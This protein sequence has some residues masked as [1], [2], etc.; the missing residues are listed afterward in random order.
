MDQSQAR[1]RGPIAVGLLLIALGGVFLVGQM[2][3]ID[4]GRYGWPL[5]II[6]PGVAIWLVALML[7]GPVGVGFS[8]AGAITTVTGFVL[9]YQDTTDHWES[10]A[11]AW[12]LI[13]PGAV[14]L[15]LAVHGLVHGDRELLDSGVRVALVGLAL[16]LV[17]G[18]FFESMVGLG[19][20]PSSTLRDTILPGGL[21]VLGIGIVLAG[22]LSGRRHRT[23]A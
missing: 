13:A 18:V 16:F 7:G 10:W 21:V 5:F 8:I 22:I 17:F 19:D 1:E 11:Y 4:F 15:A 14:G 23:P 3:D 9:L 12:A 6:V 2:V 20:N